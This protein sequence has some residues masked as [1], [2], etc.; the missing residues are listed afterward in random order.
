M[1]CVERVMILKIQSA[2]LVCLAIVFV[3]CGTSRRGMVATAAQVEARSAPATARQAAL[4]ELRL[5]AALRRAPDSFEANHNLGEF[6]IQQGKLSAAVP[7]LEKAQR[8]NPANY[9]NSYDLAMALFQTGNLPRARAQIQSVIKWKDTAEL[10]S[11]LGDVEGKAGDWVAAAEEYQRAAR[12]E[13]S[14]GRL[15]D[16]GAS[17]IKIN[18]YD[19]AAQI[20]D[21]GLKK[22]PRSAKLRIGL[23]GAYYSRGQYDGAVRLLCEAADLEPADTRPYLFLGEMYGVSAEMADEITRRMARFVEYHPSN[24]L[25]HYYY[26]VNLRQARRDAAPPLDVKQVE[27]L[28]KRAIVLNPKLAPAHF[29]LGVLY[30]ERRQYDEAISALRNA[31][32]FNPEMDKAHYRLARIYQLTGR[33]ELAAKQMEIHRRLKDRGAE[34]GGQKKTTP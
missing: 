11:L 13:E 9:V 34:S 26:A 3:V 29:E 2:I 23:G 20:F 21:Y 27:D 5:K 17:L 14:E 31:V 8:L 4:I 12:M 33:K 16:L 30:T 19:A 15:L 24:A 7:C 18:A 32:R 28:L 1:S 25:A 10:H 6:Y 22:Y